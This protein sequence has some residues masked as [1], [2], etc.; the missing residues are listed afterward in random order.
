MGIFKKIFNQDND[1][2]TGN[3]FTKI[4]LFALPV[5]LTQ[6]MQLLY[7]T[8]DLTS[9]HYGDSADS[10]GAISSN[11]PLISLIVVVFTGISLGAN[12]ILAE[13]KG[14]NDQEKAEKV[15]HNSLFLALI[16]GVFIGALGFFISDDLLKMMGTEEHYF[17]K[18]TLYLKIYFCGLPFLMIYNYAAQLLRAQGNSLDH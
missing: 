13:A 7:V 14:A 9:V 1:M 16:T 12:V 3:L 11:G 5:M 6:I 2:T 4:I 17:A 15:V 10:M 8:I 18:A